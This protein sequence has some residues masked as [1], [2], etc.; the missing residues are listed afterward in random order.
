VAS[1]SS[2][3]FPIS[4]IEYNHIV[5]MCTFLSVRLSV[6]LFPVAQKGAY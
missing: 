2:M 6:C 1:T 4:I 5:V 3:V